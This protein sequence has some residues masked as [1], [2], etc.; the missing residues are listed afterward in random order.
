MLVRL[1]LGCGFV[2]WGLGFGSVMF[3]FGFAA[4]RDGCLAGLAGI[5]SD[6]IRRIM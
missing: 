5:G 6:P 1:R 2:S 4:G 3:G